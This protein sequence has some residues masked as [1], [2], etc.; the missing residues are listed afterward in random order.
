MCNQVSVSSRLSFNDGS[1]S[2]T[3]LFFNLVV[4][5]ISRLRMVC[6]I[7]ISLFKI[8]LYMQSLPC[9]TEGIESSPGGAC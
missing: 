3:E 4:T 8:C 7:S 2:L 5:L 9:E 1:T 6:K